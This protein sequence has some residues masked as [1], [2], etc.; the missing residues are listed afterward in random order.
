MA[1]EGEGAGVPETREPVISSADPAPAAAASTA[2]AVTRQPQ[3]V[4]LGTFRITAYCTCSRCCGTWSR[5]KRTASGLPARGALVAAD[6]RVLPMLSNIHIDGVGDRLV[7]DKGRLIKG[8]RIDVLMKSHRAA[9]RFGVKRLAVF[10]EIKHAAA[11]P[12]TDD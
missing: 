10:K 3:L 1:D 7:A 11:D 5:Y 4:A 8:R 12:R 2:V 6:P 9:L